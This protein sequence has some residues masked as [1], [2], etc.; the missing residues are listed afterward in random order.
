MILRDRDRTVDP[1][2]DDVVGLVSGDLWPAIVF[3]LC[4]VYFDH[5]GGSALTRCP[6]W[7]RSSTRKTT[8]HGFTKC[9]CVNKFFFLTEG[10]KKILIHKE[11]S[12]FPSCSATAHRDLEIF[13]KRWFQSWYA[14]RG[15]R[16]PFCIAQIAK[17]TDS[18][19]NKQGFALDVIFQ[20]ETV[21]NFCLKKN[22]L[23]FF[24]EAWNAYFIFRELWKD[25]FIFRETWSRPP[26]Y[27]PLNWQRPND[28][29]F[30]NLLAF[31]NVC[32]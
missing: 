22:V 3:I 9:D 4:F 17:W 18:E 28:R 10:N 27:H 19:N 12:R 32:C 2:C 21:C 25:R 14:E 24:R 1:C 13:K 16:F 29:Y 8:L 5:N 30:R 20:N 6:R 23:L 26:L 11:Q 7:L 31:C 15:T